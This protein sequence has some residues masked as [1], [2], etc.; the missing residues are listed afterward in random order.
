[1]S[2]SPGDLGMPKGM[3]RLFFK[4][5]FWYL[6]NWSKTLPFFRGPISFFQIEDELGRWPSPLLVCFEHL[7]CIRIPG[8]WPFLTHVHFY[9]L[10]ILVRHLSRISFSSYS[11]KFDDIKKCSAWDDQDL[12][13]LFRNWANQPINPSMWYPQAS[14]NSKGPDK[15]LEKDWSQLGQLGRPWIFSYLCYEWIQ[16]VYICICIYIY[17]YVCMYNGYISSILR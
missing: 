4:I 1:M 3:T 2:E 5:N 6:Q 11:L 10:V 12:Y 9:L 16:Y 7:W 8:F 14:L 15:R 17:M 13:G